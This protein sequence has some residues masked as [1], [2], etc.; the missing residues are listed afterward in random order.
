MILRM[1]SLCVCPTFVLVVSLCC[2]NRKEHATQRTY[3]YRRGYKAVL[4]WYNSR[5]PI[6]EGGTLHTY[7]QWRDGNKAPKRYRL[8][9]FKGGNAAEEAF[10]KM[11]AALAPRND[12]NHQ[13]KA[14][15]WAFYKLKERE[16]AARR[17][18]NYWRY[19]HS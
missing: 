15:L 2:M 16:A 18:D 1:R 12:V 14:D 3:W 9:W 11:S 8:D 19:G 5:H 6:D 17:R 7:H 13:Q 10:H 4:Q